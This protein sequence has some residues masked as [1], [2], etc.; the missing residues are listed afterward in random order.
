M[1]QQAQPQP[2]KAVSM[3]P[4]YEGVRAA[5]QRMEESGSGV[6]YSL[7]GIKIGE[8]S[9]KIRF[10]GAILQCQPNVPA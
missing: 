6:K 5:R 8:L 4:V 1:A 9:G 10:P 3:N 7:S 2:V